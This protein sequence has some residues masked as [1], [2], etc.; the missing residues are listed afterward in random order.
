MMH[1]YILITGAPHSGTRLLQN[2]LGKH[3]DDMYSVLN[4]G[5]LNINFGKSLKNMFRRKILYFIQKA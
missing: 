4:K 3:P 5:R 1:N 2:M